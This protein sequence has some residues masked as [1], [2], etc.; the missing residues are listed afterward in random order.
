MPNK[1]LFPFDARKIAWGVIGTLGAVLL[2]FVAVFYLL[3][4]DPERPA[5]PD[6]PDYARIRKEMD[7]GTR[8][9]LAGYGWIDR[10][11]RVVRIPVEVAIQKLIDERSAGR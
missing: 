8:G 9:E 7:I 11:K 6:R 10:Q 5:R 1:D 2:I 4:A 3:F